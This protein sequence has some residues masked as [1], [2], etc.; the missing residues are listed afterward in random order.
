[1]GKIGSLNVKMYLVQK[2]M[3]YG[4]WVLESITLRLN[5]INRPRSKT[6]FKSNNNKKKRRVYL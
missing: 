3:S 6:Q 5:K 2:I 4:Y 1:M